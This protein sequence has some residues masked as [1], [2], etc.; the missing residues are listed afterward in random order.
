MHHIILVPGLG[1]N[2]R[3]MRFL[4]KSWKK[5]G[6]VVHIKSASWGNKET[7]KEKLR[8]LTDYIDTFAKSNRRVYLV[9]VSGGGS[10]VMNAYYQRRQKVYKVI[11]VC[12]RLRKGQKVFPTLAVA[13]LG[14]PD[15]KT[16]VLLCENN[17]KDLLEKDK[18]KIMT[19]RGFYD[20]VVP[21]STI[22]IKGATNIITPFPFHAI[23][24]AASLL[25]YKKDI[26]NFILG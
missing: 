11:N 8:N 12:G 5:H 19:L 4:T 14:F 23:A 20:E 21:G 25:V 24:I 10:L 16:S 7:Y 9:G 6:V 18:Q 3:W 17:Q 1:N 26:L 15:F 2:V 22:P 13:A